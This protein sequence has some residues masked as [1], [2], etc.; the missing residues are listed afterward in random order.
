LYNNSV[1]RSGIID[2]TFGGKLDSVCPGIVHT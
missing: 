1:D 2:G